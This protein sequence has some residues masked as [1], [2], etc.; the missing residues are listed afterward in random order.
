[1]CKL[2]IQMNV[3]VVPWRILYHINPEDT[4]IINELEAYKCKNVYKYIHENLGDSFNRPHKDYIT[5]K[6][7]ELYLFVPY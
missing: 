3:Q 7:Q 6:T 1:M 4:A 5:G 2:V